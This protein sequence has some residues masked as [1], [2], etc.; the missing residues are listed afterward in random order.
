ME[1][2]HVRYSVAVAEAENVARAALKLHIS[3]PRSS[4]QIRDRED[5]LGLS[6]FK[7]SA[8]SVRLNEAGH[9]FLTESRTVLQRV[10]NAVNTAR[11]IVTGGRG[12]LQVGYATSPT[13]RIL[14]P[15][16]RAFQEQLPNVRVRLHDLSTEE[17][18]AGVRKGKLQI[19]FIVRP[20]RAMLRGLRFEELMR[21][22]MHLAVATNHAFARLR[23]VKLARVALEALVALTRKDYPEYHEYLATLFAASKAKPRVSIHAIR[24]SHA[25]G[26]RRT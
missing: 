2:R 6:L 12:E 25:T 1:L 15:T 19:A 9:G 22:P 16:L 8:K 21:H 5:E 7:R 13:P 17:T 24:Y 3:Q 4:R 26:P 18:I 10:Q 11:A 14:P 20:S 23:S